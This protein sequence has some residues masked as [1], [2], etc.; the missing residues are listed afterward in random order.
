MSLAPVASVTKVTLEPATETAVVGS[1]E[2]VTATVTDQNGNPLPS[3]RVDFLVSGANSDE[4][5]V[6]AGTEGKATFCYTGAKVGEDSIVGSVGL[7]SGSATKTWVAA[8]AATNVTLEPATETAVVGS[9]KCVTATVTDQNGNPFPG[10]GVDFLVSGANSEEGSAVADSEGKAKFCYTGKH[11]GED[12]IVGSVGLISGSAT[13][14]WVTEPTATAT[15]T[16]TPSSG[17][18]AFKAEVPKACTSER[19]FTIHIQNAKQLGLVS[20]VVEVDG[21]DA[22]TLRGKHLSTAIDLVGLPKG[23]FTVEIVAH[24][25]D[26]RIVKGERVYHTCVPKMPGHVYLPL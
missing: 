17:V 23:T 5:S 6:F 7:I 15:P 22:K 25:R 12:S 1:E 13:K 20:A 18:L 26:G 8:L 19:E 9:E 16:A 24:R 4:G 14:T 11:T 3:V 2:C 10:V 21:K